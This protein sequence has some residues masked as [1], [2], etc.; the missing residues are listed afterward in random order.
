MAFLN[1]STK[2][3]N[4]GRKNYLAMI[5][6]RSVNNFLFSVTYEASSKPNMIKHYRFLSF[7]DKTASADFSSVSY[8][9]NLLSSLEIGD[10]VYFRLILLFLTR[11]YRSI[12]TARLLLRKMSCLDFICSVATYWTKIGGCRFI[13]KTEKS[14]VALNKL[15]K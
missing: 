11:S 3:S 10:K 13:R 15:H 2:N 12:T 1:L 14:V 8:R 6:S 4:R 9:P 5:R 7:S